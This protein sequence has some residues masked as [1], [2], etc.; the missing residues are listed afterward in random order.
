[1]RA[2]S[3]GSAGFFSVNSGWKNFW[4]VVS[5]PF[6]WFSSP[7]EEEGL[8]RCC[9]GRWGC[10]A[11]AVLL[12]DHVGTW[13]PQGG[14]MFIPSPPL[15]EGWVSSVPLKCRVCSLQR[16]GLGVSK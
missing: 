7:G 9:W 6:P 14:F 4:R 8:L 1:M 3:A 11:A 13:H 12:Q 15:Q 10:K 2:V 5:F 16:A